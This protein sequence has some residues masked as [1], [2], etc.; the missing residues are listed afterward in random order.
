MACATSMAVDQNLRGQDSF[1]EG[2][3]MLD[4]EAI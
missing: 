2:T 1:G 3:I 4:V